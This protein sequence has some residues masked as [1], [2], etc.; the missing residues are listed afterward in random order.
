MTRMAKAPSQIRPPTT[1]ASSSRIRSEWT[2]EQNGTALPPRQ[3]CG[4]T[5]LRNDKDNS[6]C[7]LGGA[8]LSIC[9]TGKGSQFPS[10]TGRGSR[11]PSYTGTYNV[12]DCPAGTSGMNERETRKYG[13][14]HKDES[15][16]LSACPAGTGGNMKGESCRDGLTPRQTAGASGS[17]SCSNRSSYKPKLRLAP[18]ARR[19]LEESPG[20]LWTPGHPTYRFVR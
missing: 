4:R 5:H 1:Q 17:R 19:T 9:P 18:S 2:T 14:R 13:F 16:G 3:S 11:F 15:L 8:N 6:G 12:P 10:Y 7:P 20:S